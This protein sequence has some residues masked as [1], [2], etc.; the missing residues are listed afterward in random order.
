MGFNYLTRL[1]SFKNF[2][3]QMLMNYDIILSNNFTQM[4]LHRLVARKI[5]WILDIQD[6]LAQ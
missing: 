6:R 1:S 4:Q 2:W 5:V 3:L